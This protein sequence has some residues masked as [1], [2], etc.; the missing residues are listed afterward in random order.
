MKANAL[1]TSAALLGGIAAGKFGLDRLQA[2]ERE[3]ITRLNLKS[4]AIRTSAG[5]IEYSLNG[6]GPVVMLIH[7]SPGGHDQ[8]FILAD[9]LQNGFSVLAPSR[10][11]YLRTP[12]QDSPSF[13]AQ[14]DQLAALLDRLNIEQVATLAIGSGAPVAFQFALRHPNRLKALIINAGLSKAHFIPNPFVQSLP[15]P[16]HSSQLG[17]ELAYALFNLGGQNMPAA[18]LNILLE[19]YTT[20]SEAERISLAER[21]LA[22]PLQVLFVQ[23]LLR[24][25]V[26]FSAR[27]EGYQ[28]DVQ[29]CAKLPRYPLENISAPTLVAHSPTDAHIDFSHAEHTAQAIPNAELL[30]VQNAGHLLWLGAEADALHDKQR[31]FL[32][33]HLG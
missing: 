7:G 14:A 23:D 1:I 31:A 20:H 16:F 13:E 6:S 29:L 5:R 28:T 32:K 24:S 26:P 15:Q 2:W 10:A 17:K 25:F 22:D 8:S 18:V 4:H 9:L 21:I 11:G 33:Q 12:A 27:A 19:Y 3:Q 30:S